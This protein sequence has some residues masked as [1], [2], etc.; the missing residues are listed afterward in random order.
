MVNLCYIYVTM[1][2]KPYKIKPASLYFSLT[3][4]TLSNFISAF[5]ASCSWD[6]KMFFLLFFITTPPFFF[7][8]YINLECPLCHLPLFP[9]L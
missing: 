7:S 9:S 8:A 5:F 4:K 2:K 3:F 6:V 1:K